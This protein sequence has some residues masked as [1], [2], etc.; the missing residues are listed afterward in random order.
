MIIHTW[1]KNNNALYLLSFYSFLCISNLVPSAVSK[2]SP[3]KHLARGDVIFR[4]HKLVI[5]VKWSKTMQ[6]AHQV[7][8]ITIPAIPRSTMCPVSTICNLLCLTPKGVNLPLFQVKNTQNWVPLTD[9]RV[10]RHFSLMFDRL[11]YSGFT[12]H[13]FWRSGATFAFSN[14]VAL[15]NIKRHST[16]TSDCEW[17][18]ITD[19]TDAGEQVAE[20]FKSKLYCTS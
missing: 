17:R 13:T 10:R 20:M 1:G 12:L 4:S 8:L 15:Q 2:F 11:A 14:N 3:L 18:Y 5:I 16:W 9:S 7:Q 19:S 6:S